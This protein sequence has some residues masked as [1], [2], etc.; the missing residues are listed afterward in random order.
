MPSTEGQ[1]PEKEPGVGRRVLSSNT[2]PWTGQA[3]PV[4]GRGGLRCHQRALAG[5]FCPMLYGPVTLGAQEGVAEKQPLVI[6]APVRPH[7][8]PPPSLDP[9]PQEKP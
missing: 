9:V 8:T 4:G 7:T 2:G 3:G 6:P 5:L 1:T